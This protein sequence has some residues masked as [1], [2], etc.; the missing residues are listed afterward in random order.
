MF[1]LVELW[2][3]QGGRSLIHRLAVAQ[4]PVISLASGAA[5]VA[6]APPEWRNLSIWL[7]AL[8]GG[9]LKLFTLA[10]FTSMLLMQLKQ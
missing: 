10:C 6:L 7:M 9:L 2:F 8:R 1:Q 3:P 4:S 5:W